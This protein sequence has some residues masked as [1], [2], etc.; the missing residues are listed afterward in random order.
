MGAA[1]LSGLSQLPHGAACRCPVSGLQ[2]TALR[3]DRALRA[4]TYGIM[5]MPFRIISVAIQA[6]IDVV[7]SRQRARQ[8]ASM[9]GFGPQDQAHN[10]TAETELARNVYNNASHG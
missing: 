9:C 4:P 8:V 5:N 2:P 1:Q 7:A 3:L 6:V 10:T